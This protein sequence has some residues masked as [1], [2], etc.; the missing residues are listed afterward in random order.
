[1]AIAA[2]HLS[3]KSNVANER[4]QSEIKRAAAE[5]A[6][7]SEAWPVINGERRRQLMR[8]IGLG[9]ICQPAYSITSSSARRN[10]LSASIGGV[11]SA[12]Q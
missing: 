10:R 2:W 9:E 7:E 12:I 4:R 5:A 11:R 3:A 8:R 1:M 6:G